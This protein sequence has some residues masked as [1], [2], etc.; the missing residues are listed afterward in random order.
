MSFAEEFNHAPHPSGGQAQHQQIVQ[1]RQ[2]H[3]DRMRRVVERVGRPGGIIAGKG[4]GINHLSPGEPGAQ[5]RIRFVRRQGVGQR[6]GID[7][8]GQM[9]MVTPDD[10]Y[11][12]GRNGK[13]HKN[14]A[15]LQ[16]DIH[17][18]RQEL[19]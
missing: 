12:V 19:I 13:R 9:R 10:P 18:H 15:V 3:I 17:N 8:Q 6:I 16:A 7:G 11:A 2:R 4:V 1:N 5:A 14:R